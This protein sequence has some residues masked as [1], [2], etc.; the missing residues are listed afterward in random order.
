[1]LK[2]HSVVTI[3]PQCPSSPRMVHI[4]SCTRPSHCQYVRPPVLCDTLHTRC[5]HRSKHHAAT[6]RCATQEVQRASSQAASRSMW[7]KPYCIVLA[8]QEFLA[9]APHASVAITS[10]A[11]IARLQ[12]GSWLP[13]HKSRASQ[14]API[15]LS[16]L[17]ENLGNHY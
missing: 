6:K 12:I 11:L 5:E 14:P 10:T 7:Q 9:S 3:S 2:S 17:I 4:R 15:V 13:H 8:S 16:A 1:M